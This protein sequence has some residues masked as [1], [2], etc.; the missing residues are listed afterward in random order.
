[1]GKDAVKFIAQQR[2][3]ERKVSHE[4][5]KVPSSEEKAQRALRQRTWS[6][7]SLNVLRVSALKVEGE[8]S[9][10]ITIY[11]LKVSNSSDTVRC[12]TVKQWSCWSN[13]QACHHPRQVVCLLEK[14]SHRESAVQAQLSLHHTRDTRG[15][16]CIIPEIPGSILASHQRYQGAFRP[17]LRLTPSVRFHAG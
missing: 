11:M 1:M 5:R 17:S 3:N 14:K 15:H 7:S 16:S 2:Q 9:A 13:L 10:N 8:V 4:Y 6:A 12:L